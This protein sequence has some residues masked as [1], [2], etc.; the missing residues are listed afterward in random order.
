[1]SRLRRETKQAV[2]GGKSSGCGFFSWWWLP[3]DELSR[4]GLSEEGQL[5]WG[6]SE[7][8]RCG[9]GEPNGEVEASPRAIVTHESLEAAR[10]SG[11]ARVNMAVVAAAAAARG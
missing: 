8:R 9:G 7:E 11:V 10:P 4:R 1:V 6:L 3:G 5:R 2:G